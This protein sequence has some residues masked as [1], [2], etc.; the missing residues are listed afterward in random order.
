[1]DGTAGRGLVRPFDAGCNLRVQLD[2]CQQLLPGDGLVSGVRGCSRT[3]AQ[4]AVEVSV[5]DAGLV[6]VCPFSVVPC[7]ARAL[8]VRGLAVPDVRVR[9]PLRRFA[10]FHRVAHA[11]GCLLRLEGA[12][13]RDCGFFGLLTRMRRK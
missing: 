11:G 4:S 12:A 3:R 13:V 1:M 7:V 2:I 6:G 10:Q 5:D 8:R 9:V